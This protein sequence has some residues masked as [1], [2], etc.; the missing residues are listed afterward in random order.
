MSFIHVLRSLMAA[1][2]LV[3]AGP[4]SAQNAPPAPA[5]APQPAKPSVPPP[6][7]QLVMIRTTLIALHQAN[8]TGNYT[9]L[10]DLGSPAFQSANS[11]A[12]LAEIFAHLRSQ[13][14]DLAQVVLVLPKLTRPSAV[15]DA[16]LLRMTGGFD[17]KPVPVAFDLLFQPVAQQWRLFGISV[18]AAAPQQ[19]AAPA[20]APPPAKATNGKTSPAKPGRKAPAPKTEAK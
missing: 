16:S 20:Q 19:P 14:I 2:A 4:A 9:V 6:E 1:A 3:V 10:R 8:V 5:P 18:S 15:S 17:L 11:A 13:G 7:N 12:R